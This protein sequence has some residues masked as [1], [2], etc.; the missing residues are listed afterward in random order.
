MGFGMLG[1]GMMSRMMGGYGYG[2]SPVGLALGLA[3]GAVIIG[4]VA[5]LVGYLVRNANSVA[6]SRE[7]PIDILKARYARGEITKEEFD[8]IKRDL[9]A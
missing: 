9:V 1:P 2:F 5:L 4:G 6:P 3:F 7:V 8:M